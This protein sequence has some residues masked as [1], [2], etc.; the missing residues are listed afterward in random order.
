M[1]HRE[2]FVRALT[3]R[4]VDR[5]PFIKVF[6]GD[7]AIAAHWEKEFPG[8]GRRID[9]I[10]RFDGEYRGWQVAPVDMNP[11]GFGPETVVEED[12]TKRIIRRGD[13]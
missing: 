4:E 6:G 11:C 2:R 7:N 9:E 8:I 3:G 12:D 5:V 1:T 13:C 10:L